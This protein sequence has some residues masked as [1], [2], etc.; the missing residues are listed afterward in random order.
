MLPPARWPAMEAA[1]SRLGPAW[2]RLARF[3]YCTCCAV[4]DGARALRAQCPLPMGASCGRVRPAP[5]VQPLLMGPSCANGLSVRF[6]GGEGGE[7]GFLQL[8]AAGTSCL[9]SL[10]R[11]QRNEPGWFVGE[12][13][14]VRRIFAVA[15]PPAGEERGDE[16]LTDLVGERLA[17]PAGSLTRESEADW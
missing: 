12:H 6:D 14:H 17:P 10:W 13:M 2:N 8:P 7:D 11:L 16:T 15:A 3:L 1:E 9:R 4:G 5:L